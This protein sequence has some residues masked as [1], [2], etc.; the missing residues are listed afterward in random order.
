MSDCTRFR[1]L[2]LLLSSTVCTR[3]KEY[4]TSILCVRV[5]WSLLDHEE[6]LQHTTTAN[7]STCGANQSTLRREK[8]W[9]GARLAQPDR[10]PH[11]LAG[12]GFLEPAWNGAVNLQMAT[13]ALTLVVQY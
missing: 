12:M 7:Q 1:V 13:G 5:S 3:Q 10:L 9:D 4:R 11:A 8:A 2:F 6:Y